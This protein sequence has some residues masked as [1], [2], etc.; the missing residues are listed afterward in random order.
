LT[1]VRTPLFEM[2]KLSIELLLATIGD[3]TLPPQRVVCPVSLV[4]RESTVG[5]RQ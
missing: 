1:S 5:A 2:G 4:V 3:R